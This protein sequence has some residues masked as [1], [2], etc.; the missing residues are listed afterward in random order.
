M[1]FSLEH[2]EEEICFMK[3]ESTQVNARL[4]GLEQAMQEVL[5]S[6]AIPGEDR[7]LKNSDAQ[8]D[9]GGHSQS[10]SCEAIDDDFDIVLINK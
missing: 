1:N 9:L 6:E 2:L 10:T 8:L 5:S 7:A 3:V 4:A